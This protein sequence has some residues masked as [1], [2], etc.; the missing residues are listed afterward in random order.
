MGLLKSL[1]SLLSKKFKTSL[2]PNYVVI[3]LETTGFSPAN[4]R[5]IEL[6]AVKVVNDQIV[7]QFSTLINP[8]IGIKKEMENK[9]GITNLMVANAPSIETVLP[10]FLNFINGSVIVGHNVPFDIRF[11]TYNFD[12]ISV[13]FHCRY[14]DT[15]EYSRRV[16]PNLRQH[17]LTDLCSYFH[18]D[19]NVFHRALADCVSTHKCFQR[20]MKVSDKIYIKESK[21]TLRRVPTKLTDTNMRLQQLYELLRD[22]MADDI[23]TS[24]E[25]YILKDW[26]DNNDDLFNDYPYS[27][28]VP[29]VNRILADG[30]ITNDESNELRQIFQQVINPKFGLRRGETFDIAGKSFVLT[31]Q[32]ASYD[33][34]DFANMLIEKGG[35]LMKSVSGK[36]D[37]L[38]VGSNPDPRWHS[39]N[40]GTK[41]KK[42][43]ELRTNGGGIIIATE[44]EA[45]NY[46]RKPK[47]KKLIK[48]P[49]RFS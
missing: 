19:S 47:L 12:R 4:D 39:G 29:V 25:V 20:L 36:T 14:I 28:I 8:K 30:V 21:V 9:T 3:D 1:I 26:I 23:V 34:D 6:A 42:A 40:F 43:M 22:I 7:D 15:L 5:I 49:Q 11:L 17:R 41:I 16:L 32:F 10:Q 33:P 35:I 27:I 24:E 37:Y 18:I 13:Q 48:N 45:L 2:I 44:I 46:L 38:I 31:G